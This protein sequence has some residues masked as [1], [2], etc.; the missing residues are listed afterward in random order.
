MTGALT[1]RV[2]LSPGVCFIFLWAVSTT[3]AASSIDNPY[4]H[5]NLTMNDLNSLSDRELIESTDDRLAAVT[6]LLH[7]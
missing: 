5:G 4:P 3:L 7:R 2:G 1:E 6:E